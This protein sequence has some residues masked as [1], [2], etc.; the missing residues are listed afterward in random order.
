MVLS[1]ISNT[2]DSFPIAFSFVPSES[3]VCFDFIF[4]SLKE[5][6]W[7]EYPLPIVIIG[8]QAKELA[9]S[10]P[11]SMPSSTPQYC[12]W[13]AA[14]NIRKYLI[15]HGYAKDKINTTKPLI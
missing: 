6:A 2:G 14:E 1:G 10:L 5:L 8:D 11:Y 4:E 12:E 9:A 7:E 15:D 13:H 3:K